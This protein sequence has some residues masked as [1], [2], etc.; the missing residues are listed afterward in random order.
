[1]LNDTLSLAFRYVNTL[2]SKQHALNTEMF[3]QLRSENDEYLEIL[4][5]HTE[6]R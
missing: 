2:K 5:M 1:M 6:V 3:K 4:M